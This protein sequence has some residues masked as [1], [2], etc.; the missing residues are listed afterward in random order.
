MGET[1]E[2]KVKYQTARSLLGFLTALG[3]ATAFIAAVFGLIATV[4]AV[5]AG[6]D[7]SVLVIAFA[8][9]GVVNGIV[10]V[11][12]SQVGQAV[13]DTAIHYCPVKLTF[14]SRNYL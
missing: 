9:A 13:I 2:P 11:A 12:V 4:N 5:T 8:L 14:P 7:S 1:L 10:I 6:S 3:W